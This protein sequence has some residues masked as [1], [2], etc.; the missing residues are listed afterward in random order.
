M[1]LIK[2]SFIYKGVTY[3]LRYVPCCKKKCSKCP[4]GP[5]WYAIVPTP[6]GKPAVR[7]VGKELKG[8]AKEYRTT[9]RAMEVEFE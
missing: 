2:E 3:Q 7:Y 8:P 6:V 4:H 5:Y 9:Q 1:S